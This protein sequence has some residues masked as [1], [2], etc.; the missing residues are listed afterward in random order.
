MKLFYNGFSG[1]G[2]HFPIVESW[3]MYNE[4]AW[5]NGKFKQAFERYKSLDN[6]GLESIKDLIDS[7]EIAKSLYYF[8]QKNIQNSGKMVNV[9]DVWTVKQA[10]SLSIA[11]FTC[12]L[13]RNKGFYSDLVLIA[14][15]GSE[16]LNPL[17]Y[18]VDNITNCVVRVMINNVSYLL[19]P[20]LKDYPFGFLPVY[21][22]NGY[23]R[24]VNEAG[25]EIN[26][27]SNLAQNKTF[28][29]VNIKPKEGKGN[30]AQFTVNINTKYG[31][32]DALGIRSAW[33]EDSV[34]FKKRFLDNASEVSKTLGFS[35]NKV[36]LENYDNLDERLN[37]ILEGQV[38]FGKETDMIIYD[39]YFH[40]LFSENPLK[41]KKVRKYPVEFDYVTFNNYVL[42]FALGDK[43]EVEELPKNTVLNFGDPAII[44]FSQNIVH[45]KN[46][47]VLKLSYKYVNDATFVSSDD[48]SDLREY[49]NTILKNFNQKIVIKKK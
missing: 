28:S 36:R 9:K 16:K 49:F 29:N 45:D 13:F 21:Y 27:T 15:K 41:E 48:A 5:Y 19:E 33:K 25:G 31:V 38:N 10:N 39:P 37:L 35:I 6:V 44:K 22:Y 8:V 32:Y 40:K 23:S 30:D 1:G 11:M 26:I 2:Y 12:A 20:S 47:N 34:A 17:L 24:V 42:Q 14:N 7:L 46:S 4:K 18:N 43:Y 3:D